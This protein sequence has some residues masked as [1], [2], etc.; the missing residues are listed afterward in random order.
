M[1]PQVVSGGAA[2]VIAPDDH[3]VLHVA[4]ADLSNGKV[5][6]TDVQA[7]FARLVEGNVLFYI[8]IDGVLLAAPFSLKNRA[9]E[10]TSIP[11][12]S[13][14]AISANGGAVFALSKNGSVIYSQGF[15]RGSGR[16]LRHVSLLDF[17]GK[18]T[19]LSLPA[20]TISSFRL[21]PDRTRIA[22]T[23]WDGGMNLYDLQR[24]T[25]M[26]LPK[27]NIQ[28][29]SGPVWTPD[30]NHIAYHG[31]LKSVAPMF[32][33]RADGSDT[34][35]PLV[36]A[37]Q[38]EFWPGSFSP[39]AR[40][41]AYYTIEST[42][43]QR[44]WE[45]W[46]MPMD[47]PSAAKRLATGYNPQIS[48]DGRWI[49]YESSESGRWEIYIQSFPPP[50]RRA[51]LS[52]GGGK[53]ATWSPDSHR[54]YYWQENMLMTVDVG[55]EVG[56]PAAMFEADELDMASSRRVA[57]MGAVSDGFIVLAP[58]AGSGVQTDLK[59]ATGWVDEVNRK[60]SAEDR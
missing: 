21:S 9:L 4:I 23:M 58:V 49:A 45:V 51:L 32:I 46:L 53:G 59:L 19:P 15:V 11:I 8:R 16:E 43:N 18:L 27:G 28:E 34:P 60:L 5:A 47:N 55:M 31:E 33:Q 17:K 38:G 30:G 24:K 42:P 52:T 25:R 10:G 1:W 12:I 57:S 37:R 22:F 41:L 14:V 6:L 40:W 35:R 3:G 54:L 7:T 56:I 29:K 39:D 50:G 44:D 36:S 2:L 13:D 20:D 26:K 48:P